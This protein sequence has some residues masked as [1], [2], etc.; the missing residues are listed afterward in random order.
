MS[1]ATAKLNRQMTKKPHVQPLVSKNVASD[2]P[3]Q[4]A[5]VLSAT[6]LH[7]G[8]S[9]PPPSEELATFVPTLDSLPKAP[10]SFPV[11]QQVLDEFIGKAGVMKLVEGF[12]ETH[13]K[14]EPLAPEDT[15][16]N[17]EYPKRCRGMCI[18]GTPVDVLCAH[19]A[20]LKS[21]EQA[22]TRD[23]LAEGMLFVCEVKEEGGDFVVVCFVELCAVLG[24]YGRFPSQQM[25][26]ELEV[27]SPGH[28]E[29]G[30]CAGLVLRATRLPRVEPDPAH[31]FQCMQYFAANSG[32]T[33]RLKMLTEAE[34]SAKMLSHL[35][36]S[37]PVHI[38]LRRL[39]Y[40]LR[41]EGGLDELRVTRPKDIGMGTTTASTWFPD[42]VM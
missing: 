1:E 39:S 3:E 38:R 4:L 19:R 41:C 20:L 12:K 5:V 33:G 37:Y 26:L 11:S 15:K 21:L 13:A 35:L 42:V 34:L 8:V 6:P 14:V 32:Q 9:S 27:A 29:V 22:C 24:R 2:P 28:A 31:L 18:V 30:D 40:R 7:V 36:P 10:S 16:Q 17:V 23:A 25:F